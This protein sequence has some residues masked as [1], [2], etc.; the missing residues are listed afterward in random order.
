MKVTWKSATHHETCLAEL[1]LWTMFAERSCA[2]RNYCSFTLH[3]LQYDSFSDVT[4]ACTQE[5]K[6]TYQ[7]SFA[8][9]KVMTASQNILPN[10]TQQ[11]QFHSDNSDEEHTHDE[12][13]YESAGSEPLSP[14]A[15]DS[16][17]YKV[18][19]VLQSLKEDRRNNKGGPAHNG[20]NSMYNNR[21]T[22]TAT[23]GTGQARSQR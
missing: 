15:C 1:V 10:Q 4:V 7:S 13:S 14:T 3:L 8:G 21:R 17:N 11:P 18:L 5:V 22:P 2:T 6:H 16:E 19:H 20:T 23:W 9:R 12:G